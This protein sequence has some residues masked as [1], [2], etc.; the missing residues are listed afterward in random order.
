MNENKEIPSFWI[1]KGNQHVLVFRIY[2]EFNRA[3]HI[4]NI[5]KLMCDKIIPQIIEN[6]KVLCDKLEHFEI[7]YEDFW[8]LGL[9]FN[10]IKE[11]EDETHQIS[12]ETWKQVYNKLEE[13]C[14]NHNI[15]LQTFYII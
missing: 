14:E 13:Y 4:E 7:G 3:K 9:N 11:A 12:K 8:E 1:T 10:H 15:T 6:S 5:D 2:C